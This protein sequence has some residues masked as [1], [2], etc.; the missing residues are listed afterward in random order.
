MTI[1]LLTFLGLAAGHV[2]RRLTPYLIG[3]KDT[4]IPFKYP[5]VEICGGLAFFLVVYHRGADPA[6]LKW[7]ALV[8]LLLAVASTD[9]LSKY[10]PTLVCYIGAGLGILLAALFPV[11][12]LT[13]YDQQNF[14]NVFGLPNYRIHMGGAILAATGA[15]M[16]FLEMDL[17][18]RIF[19][20]IAKME[21]MGL[22]DALLMLM[23]GSFLG[24]KAIIFALLPACLL[25]VVMGY[26]WKLVFKVNHFPFG[27]SLAL[28][29]FATLLYGDYMIRGVDHFHA[30]LNDLPAIFL[31]GF[32]LTLIVLLIYLM[33]RLKKKAAL[34]E[35]MIEEDYQKIDEKMKS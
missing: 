3:W 2:I 27:P 32:S 24:P 19:R 26:L 7:L 10:I 22:G 25:G 33:L 18:R 16:G 31:L 29:S 28:G 6:Q 30:F 21:V 15:A 1:L 17:I 14:L 20:P 9:H 34:Y 12:I 5:W 11:D 23:A 13:M 35:Q 4:S 8:C